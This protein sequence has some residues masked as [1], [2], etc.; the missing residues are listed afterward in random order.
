[1]RNL[2]ETEARNNKLEALTSVCTLSVDEGT[3]YKSSDIIKVIEHC[4]SGFKLVNN[5]IILNENEYLMLFID[6]RNYILGK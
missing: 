4:L 2:E 6:I 1:M 3:T 5:E